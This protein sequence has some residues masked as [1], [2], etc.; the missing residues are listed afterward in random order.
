MNEADIIKER[1]RRNYYVADCIGHALNIELNNEIDHNI[2]A[3]MRRFKSDPS[4]KETAYK[5]DDLVALRDEVLNR[6]NVCD[7]GSRTIEK[8][9]R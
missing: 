5:I 9:S 1:L 4:D 7:S 6:L 2:D 3:L 8:I